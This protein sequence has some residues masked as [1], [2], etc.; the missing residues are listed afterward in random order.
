MIVY[1]Y[2]FYGLGSC[3][4]AK[5]P[6][7]GTLSYYLLCAN[8]GDNFEFRFVGVGTLNTLPIVHM[9]LYIVFK[10]KNQKILIEQIEHKLFK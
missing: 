1:S 6:N 9:G 4:L 8:I 7:Q 3:L 10:I 5:Q 2:L